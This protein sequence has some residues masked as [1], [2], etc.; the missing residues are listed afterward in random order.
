MTGRCP[1]LKERSFLH[2]KNVRWGNV[3]SI[4]KKAVLILLV[5]SFVISVSACS[6]KVLKKTSDEQESTLNTAQN[7]YRT[8]TTDASAETESNQADKIK[9][10]VTIDFLFAGDN[11]VH[12]TLYN[13]AS[14]NAEGN[15]YDF[16]STYE[17]IAPIIK[18]ADFAVLNQ[19]TIVTDDF[20]PSS[21]PTFASPEAVGDHMVKIGFD[22]MSISNNH[23]LDYG[24]DGL[25]STLNY[26]KTKHP[27]ITVYGAY[28]SKEDRDNI[29]I[30]EIK[31]V[32]VA[33]LGFME[34]TNG[35][36]LP[37]EYSS[38][39]TYLD[40]IDEIERKIKKADE[41]ADV[42]IVSPHFGVE[43]INEV[44]DE[45][46]ELAKKFTEWGA[47]IIVGCQPHTV[48]KCDWVEADNGNKAF[49]YYCL[50]NMVSAMATC[51][52]SVGILGRLELTY[53]FKN[54]EVTITNPRAIPVVTHISGI[55]QWDVFVY[56]YSEYTAA[57]ASQSQ[58]EDMSIEN[59]EYYLSFIPKQYLSDK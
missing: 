30:K 57:L 15:G 5:F 6:Q 39:V 10:T 35:I 54:N 3:M 49:C 38:C 12:D 14:R 52:T 29:K 13:Q 55:Y 45:Q 51:Q 11:L 16:S 18:N 9:D 1:L 44:T 24:I 34:H 23:V 59:I 33:F 7:S 22:A 25:M 27:D 26:W 50:G 41:L 21:Y 2:Y 47:D 43:I 32:K 17:R 46:Y 20:G 31:G 42:V 53:D 37:D 28:E 36:S 8:E 19:E 4:V 56:P 48:Q 58:V 40:E